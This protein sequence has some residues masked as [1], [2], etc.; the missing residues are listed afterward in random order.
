MI[1]SELIIFKPVKVKESKERKKKENDNKVPAE[2]ESNKLF[3]KV[4]ENYV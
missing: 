4:S 1:Q 3:K 2:V